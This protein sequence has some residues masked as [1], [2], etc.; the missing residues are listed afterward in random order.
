MATVDV[1]LRSIKAAQLTW[2]EVDENWTS[3]Q[4]GTVPIGGI[5]AVARNVTA[6]NEIPGWL[7]CDGG[8]YNRTTYTKLFGEVGVFYGDGNGSTTFNIP[9]YRGWFLRG[10]SY[11]NTIDP[12]EGGRAPPNTGVATDTGSAQFSA[13]A[14]HDHNLVNNSTVGGPQSPPAADEV[15]NRENTGNN[16][17]D[18][19]LSSSVA[20]SATLGLSS[21]PQNLQSFLVEESDESRPTNVYVTYL[22][23]CDEGV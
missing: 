23:K 17:L 16:Q 12:D 3:L 13:I 1:T 22:I 2:D 5:V 8:E 11:G 7:R 19:S 10:T 15:L 4:N 9:D 21:T 14:T 18:Y 20:T 6:G